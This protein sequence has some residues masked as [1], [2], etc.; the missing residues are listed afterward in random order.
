MTSALD[1]RVQRQKGPPAK[2]ALFIFNIARRTMY[3]SAF[4]KGSG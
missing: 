3:Q 4:K 1:I 2:E